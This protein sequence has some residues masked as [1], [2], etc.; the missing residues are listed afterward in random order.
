M[1]Q[2][3]PGLGLPE[4]VAGFERLR[5]YDKPGLALSLLLDNEVTFR[6][7]RDTLFNT[8]GLSPEEREGYIQRLK[9]TA[10]DS[11]VGRAMI[12]IATNPLTWMLFV[13]STPGMAAL[14]GGSKSIFNRGKAY[15]QWIEKEKPHLMGILQGSKVL[16]PNQL[17]DKYPAVASLMNQYSRGRDVDAVR[18]QAALQPTSSRVLEALRKKTGRKFKYNL[19]RTAYR[20]G[21]P[22]RQI[23]DRIESAVEGSLRGVD[24]DTPHSLVVSQ[25]RYFRDATVDSQGR[26]TQGGTQVLE[27]ITDGEQIRRIEQQASSQ[28]GMQGLF[29][30]GETGPGEPMPW[31]GNLPATRKTRVIFGDPDTPVTNVWRQSPDDP[32]V[33]RQIDEE[34]ILGFYPRLDTVQRPRMTGDLDEH[35]RA[36]GRSFGGDERL[37]VE[38]RDSLRRFYDE[39]LVELFGDMDAY[40][41]AVRSGNMENAFV[42]DKGKIRR[43]LEAQELPIHQR[44]EL[45]Q[46]LRSFNDPAIDR[47]SQVTNSMLS[48]EMQDAITSGSLSRTEMDNLV[49][50][51]WQSM[52]VN[53]PAYLPRIVKDYVEPGTGR[54]LKHHEVQALLNRGSARGIERGRESMPRTKHEE[55]WMPDDLENLREFVS[56]DDREAFSALSGAISRGRKR[57]ADATEPVPLLRFNTEKRAV[58]HQ[59]SVSHSKRM[60]LEEPDEFAQRWLN[61]EGIPVDSFSTRSVGEGLQRNYDLMVGPGDEYLR[62]ALRDRLIPQAMGYRTTAHTLTAAAVRTGQQMTGWLAETAPFKA[63]EQSGKR[64]AD[65]V[66]GMRDFAVRDVN[67]AG[68]AGDL[69]GYLYSTHMGFNTGSVVLNASQPFLLAGTWLGYKQVVDAYPHAFREMS[70]YMRERAG[71]SLRISDG[72]RMDLFRKHFKH[73]D[74]MEITGDSLR[75]LDR[76]AFSTVRPEKAGA[77]KYYSVELPM[78]GF[79]KVE[80]INRSVAAHATELAY[81]RAGRDIAGK[82]RVAFME[83]ALRVVQETQFGS[84]L[85]NTPEIFTTWPVANP[86]IRQFLSFPLRSLT[87]FAHTGRV[88]DEGRR[89]MFGFSVPAM[90]GDLVRGAGASAIIYEMGK[91]LA[92]ADLTRGLF[93]QSTF[94]LATAS[95]RFHESS[96]VLPTP[97]IVDIPFQLVKGA[98]GDGDEW[99]YAIGRTLPGGVAFTRLLGMV[100]DLGWKEK[101]TA[102]PRGILGVMQRTYADWHNPNEDGLVPVFSA[103]RRLVG[104]HS[105]SEMI[106]RALGAD[107]NKF[108]EAGEIDGYLM[109][110]REVM[111]DYKRRWLA[112]TV[113]GRHDVAA[114]IEQEYKRRTGGI[115]LPMMVTTRQ[116][117]QFLRGREVP[118]TERILDRMDVG[119]RQMYMDM[120]RRSPGMDHLSRMGL[121]EEEFFSGQTASSRRARRPGVPGTSPAE[122][123]KLRRQ[124]EEMQRGIKESGAEPRAFEPF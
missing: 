121:T 22:E 107:L 78:K 112:A 23:L 46:A 105:P 83:D 37:L 82:D 8:Q 66:E 99:R 97:P 76:I 118:R 27:E 30:L 103:D 58:S 43:I 55:W 91:E 71:M 9:Q 90:F 4:H 98:T 32:D 3:V 49:D 63:I 89:K 100:P 47:G 16:T 39:G 80:W 34:Q 123:E 72:Q 48:R 52:R 24:R 102:D 12:G 59:K 11:S 101:P 51:L 68:V 13:T 18:F 88:M 62:D 57:I 42:P 29:D 2:G 6:G 20:E 25:R 35:L 113:D 117:D 15:R 40:Q 104:Y 7:M 14:R 31:G 44:D 53:Q 93:F 94:D 106:L 33:L 108:T 87:G 69:A 114:R 41:A 10:G 38:Y 77:L 28:D 96:T 86:L 61:E 92:G 65:F 54:V 109:K 50:S 124:V 84:G 1:P 5:S 73:A 74:L 17:F 79:E 116:V 115:N 122:I 36:M 85:M 110:Q 19:D 67:A 81:R 119:T 75:D 70:G 26:R 56:P 120:I 60:F 95:G 21:T 111:T 64:G 45:G